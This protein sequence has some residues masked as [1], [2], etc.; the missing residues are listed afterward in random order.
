LL[1]TLVPRRFWNGPSPLAVGL[2]GDI[3]TWISITPCSLICLSLS[4]RNWPHLRWRARAKDLFVMLNHKLNHCVRGHHVRCGRT[5]RKNVGAAESGV[6]SAR[7]AVAS[8]LFSSSGATILFSRS[9]RVPELPCC[10]LRHLRVTPSVLPLLLL[11]THP[12]TV[13]MF[14]AL[15]RLEC[16]Y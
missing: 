16:S 10:F 7:D 15:M 2:Q 11:R 13:A 5:R 6:K 12:N 9:P 1:P 3:L 4:V 8:E 14:A